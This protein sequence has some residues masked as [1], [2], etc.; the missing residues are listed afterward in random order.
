VLVSVYNG[1][2]L[3]FGRQ[4]IEHDCSVMALPNRTYHFAIIGFRAG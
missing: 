1:K 4:A 3:P 2:A